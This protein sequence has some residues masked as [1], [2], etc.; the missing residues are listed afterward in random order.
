MRYAITDENIQKAV[1][2]TCEYLE[3]N[4][5]DRRTAKRWT[6]LMEQ[7]L[8]LY[9]EQDGAAWF[10]VTCTRRRWHVRVRLRVDGAKHDHLTSG[11]DLLVEKLLADPAPIWRYGG[12]RNTVT[13][14]TAV[15]VPGI[16][17]LRFLLP[18]LKKT[19]W[20]CAA[21]ILAQIVTIAA[22][23]LLPI[24][25]ATLITAI[26]DSELQ[27]ILLLAVMLTVG[28]ILCYFFGHLSSVFFVRVYNRLLND[29][30]TDLS[31]RVF[32]LEDACI[33]RVG[34][35]MLIQRMVGD[36]ESVASS[37]DRITD[38]LAT[39]MK[40]LGIIIAVG[41]LSL[42]LCLFFVFTAVLTSVL[43]VRRVR[44]RAQDD[45]V[46]RHKRDRY[47][48]FISEMIYGVRD[49]K[50]QNSTELFIDKM[51]RSIR[52]A[53]RANYRM[54]VGSASRMFARMGIKE[55]CD[56]ILYAGMVGL[57]VLGDLKPTEA[58]VIFNYNLSVA[59]LGYF[60]GTFFDYVNT[61]SVSSER[62]FQILFSP[63]FREETFGTLW[64]AEFKGD[65]SFR[66]V[67]FTYPQEDL[68]RQARPI[69]KGI[70][71]DIRSGEKI[72]IVGRSGAGKTTVFNLLT[73]LYRPTAGKILIDGT[74]L[75]ALDAAYLRGN[76][77]A[78]SQNPYIFNM[79][80]REN[81]DLARENI[82]REEMERACKAA[83]I[84]DDIMAM[85]LQFDT[86]LGE[87]GVRLSGGQRQRLA[88]A[89][90]LLRKTRMILL[91][92]ATSA[93]DNETQGVVMDRIGELFADC[94]VITVAHRL[95]TIV[96]SDR[97]L[98]LSEGKILA[99]GS[100]AQLLEQCEAYRQLYRN[101]WSKQ[102]A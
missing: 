75:D 14:E 98:F 80:V 68:K 38:A 8:L 47:T 58:L 73:G 77:S 76:I 32:R 96:S 15:P 87:G 41:F 9:R 12:G 50:L 31:R 82:S 88:I 34:T 57:M 100:H 52:E 59:T 102:E 78:V 60:I 40:S 65:I 83:C 56:L 2:S 3:T 19:K 92:E 89:R 24:I 39:L 4:S 20:N 33:H 43:E 16:W 45:R 85:P 94:T 17:N 90:C 22:N 44:K 74:E 42:P 5:V 63:E 79:T 30:E 72:A 97:I 99:E 26:T 25:T 53:N 10:S 18:Y 62:I 101:E 61:I 86:V 81:L 27:K 91:D 69:L 54:E 66:N 6:L 51:S 70:D 7:L 64:P 71:L 13:F 48:G 36:T 23:I 84:Y 21:A 11:E 49:I 46:F 1:G 35:G 67:S 55:I 29:L 37:F 95:S 28:N 93:L